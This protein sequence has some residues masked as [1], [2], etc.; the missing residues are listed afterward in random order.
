[1][2][3]NLTARGVRFRDLTGEEIDAVLA[4]NRVGRLAFA[5]HDR[6]DIQPLHYVYDN[7]W[8]YG[9]TSEGEKTGMV[10]HNQW[11]AFEVDE[12]EDTFRWR[13]V[14]VHA[15]FNIIDPESTEASAELWAK[16]AKLIS[17]V[18]PQAFTDEDPVPFRDILFRMSI[19]D[20][21]GREATPTDP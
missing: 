12:V 10:Q 15:S 6:V 18:V 4:R 19:H 14:V 5:F 21:R 20:V 11:V 13:S 8:L 1:L 7:G 2:R 17:I 16:A 9:R 3:D